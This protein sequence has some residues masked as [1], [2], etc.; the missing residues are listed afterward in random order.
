VPP[1]ASAIALRAA[2]AI[3]LR[4]NRGA[5]ISSWLMMALLLSSCSESKISQCQKLLNITNQ[6]KLLNQEFDAELKKL[7][8]NTRSK[9]IKEVK[10]MFSKASGIFHNTAN[11][12][13]KINQDARALKFEDNKIQAAKV[14][15]IKLL[16]NYQKHL[17]L[18]ANLT[19]EFNQLNSINEAYS[20]YQKLEQNGKSAFTQLPKLEIQRQNLDR[21]IN[22]YCQQK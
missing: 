15:Y 9:D 6:I 19:L 11:K 12:V 3:A 1:R 14:Q 7:P 13:I 17:T 16:E 8:K 20:K 21:E 10:S 4:Q 5:I 2:Q 22:T 18:L